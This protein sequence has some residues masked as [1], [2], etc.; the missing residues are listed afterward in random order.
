MKLFSDFVKELVEKPL[1]VTPGLKGPIATGKD[2]DYEVFLTKPGRGR[3][4]LLVKLNA[5]SWAGAPMGRTAMILVHCAGR[6]QVMKA[7]LKRCD[8][9]GR[10]FR[11]YVTAGEHVLMLSA[12]GEVVPTRS[13]SVRI[14]RHLKPKGTRPRSWMEPVITKVHRPYFVS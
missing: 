13:D 2:N 11:L 4:E 6:E 8:K 12:S 9:T 7:R 1:I 3:I 14:K 10:H 5:E